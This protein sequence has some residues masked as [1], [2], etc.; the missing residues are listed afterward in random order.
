MK[1]YLSIIALSVFAMG[2]HAAPN[3]TLY[4]SNSCPYCHYAKDFINEHLVIEYPDMIVTQVDVG[5]PNNGKEFQA[6]LKKCEYERGGIPVVVIDG[7][8]FQG[9]GQ[10]SPEAF[11]NAANA[12]LSES[13]VAAAAARRAA[14]EK[15]PDAVRREHATAVAA[16]AAGQPVAKTTKKNDNTAMYGFAGLI[17]ILLVALGFVIFSKRKKK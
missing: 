6:A 13:D 14:L 11:R 16:R 17:A 2:A 9:F 15:N 3:L 10:N 5:N 4:Y 12:N 1:K 7:K 8:C